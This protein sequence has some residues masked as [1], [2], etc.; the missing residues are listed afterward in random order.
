MD[1]ITGVTNRKWRHQMIVPTVSCYYSIHVFRF[2]A[3]RSQVIYDFP[4]IS[5]DGLSISAARA[6]LR[7]EVT[8]LIDIATMV[9]N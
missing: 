1:E 2:T 3:Y 5:Y 7:P 8:S 6:R 4:E 9:F